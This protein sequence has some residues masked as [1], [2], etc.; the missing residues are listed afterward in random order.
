[1]RR[2]L[3]DTDSNTSACAP[4]SSWSRYPTAVPEATARRR[5]DSIA[6]AHRAKNRPVAETRAGGADWAA[7]ARPSIS[8]YKKAELIRN[9]NYL[10]EHGPWEGIDAACGHHRRVGPL[11]GHHPT[12]LRQR[13]AHP[14]PT[15]AGL[16]PTAGTFPDSNTTAGYNPVVV[17]HERAPLLV[18]HRPKQSALSQEKS[19]FTPLSA[20]QRRKLEARPCPTMRRAYA[21]STRGSPPMGARWWSTS[22]PPSERRRWQ[23]PRTWASIT[24]NYP[25][26]PSVRRIADP[27]HY[28]T[29]RF[30][31]RIPNQRTAPHSRLAHHSR[32]TPAP[33]TTAPPHAASHSAD[34]PAAAPSHSINSTLIVT[35]AML[36]MILCQG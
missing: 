17:H 28:V 19:T 35:W 18:M 36:Y 26:G 32:C 33:P 20:P 16:H 6:I 7:A 9:R 14:H 8:W 4:H 11:G 27:A 1:M 21:L 25:P 29:R 12:P 30:P 24:V 22:L 31:S 2:R 3:S 10:D 15:R 13:H 23:L 5:D 34:T